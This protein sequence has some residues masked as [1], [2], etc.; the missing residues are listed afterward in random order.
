[1][2]DQALSPEEAER[3]LGHPKPLYEDRKGTSR[4]AVAYLRAVA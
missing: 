3:F 2:V 1:M 4:Q